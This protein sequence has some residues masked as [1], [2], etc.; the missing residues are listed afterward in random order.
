M[1]STVQ[2]FSTKYFKSRAS[3]AVYQQNL[4]FRAISVGTHQRRARYEQDR[5]RKDR[6]EY[7]R[8]QSCRLRRGNFRHDA[9]AGEAEKAGI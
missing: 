4:R 2:P 3:V 7:I 8:N 5:E 1:D 6:P 9:P